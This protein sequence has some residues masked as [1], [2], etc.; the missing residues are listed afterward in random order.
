MP[1]MRMNSLKSRAINCG[2]L[3]EMILGFASGYFS[4]A[5]SRILSIS[6][7]FIYSRNSQCTID[8]LYPSISVQHVTQVIKRA[9]QVNVGNIDV[10]VLVRLQRLLK[11]RPF[12]RGLALPSRQQSGLVQHPPYTRRTYRH[13]L[14]IQHHERQPPVAFHRILEVKTDDGFLFPRLQPEIAGDPTVVLVHSSVALPPVVELA[15]PNPQPLR[16]SSDA[17][18][19]ILRPT[20]DK[21]YHLIPHIM[22]H[23][24]LRSEERRVGKECR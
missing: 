4:L 6:A 7:S 10:P 19:G 2:P 14:R 20:S 18:L 1:E 9:R 16:E 12:A 21:I 15:D 23:P 11:P 17:D 24:A 22:W 3:S 8:R 13:H 5:R